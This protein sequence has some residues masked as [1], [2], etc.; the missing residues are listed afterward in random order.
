MIFKNTLTLV[1]GLLTLVIAVIQPLFAQIPTNGS[2]PAENRI[3]GKLVWDAFEPQR[4]VLQKSSAVIYTDEKSRIKSVYGVVVSETGHVLT[5]ASEIEGKDN[6]SLRI[7][8]EVYSNVEILGVDAQWDVAMLKV[9]SDQVFTP[10]KLSEQDDV[11]QG[12]WMIS[13]GSTTRSLRRVRIGIASAVTREIKSSTSK[14]ILG[15]QLGADKKDALKIEKVSAKSGA[16][17][18]GLKSGDMLLSAGGVKLKERADLLKAMKGKKPGDKLPI[19]LLRDKKK[20]KFDVEL[21]ARPGGKQRMSRNDQMSGGE[22]SLSKRRTGFPRVIHHDT[23]LTKSSVGG[24]LLALDG[25][26]V[27]MNIAR[28]SRVA[29]FAIPARELREIIAEMIK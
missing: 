28:A 4:Q 22:N 24:P 6:L 19:E 29:T 7:G 18:A 2:L 8:A 23:P 27:G 16:E 11:E 13:N 10:V 3:N 26:C 9:N 5:K 1:L 20:M 25:T 21:M 17:K 12:H 15:V 14:V